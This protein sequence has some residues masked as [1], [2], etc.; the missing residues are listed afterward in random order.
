MASVEG[1]RNPETVSLERLE[2]SIRR[3]LQL[4]STLPVSLTEEREFSN[5]NYIFR[6]DIPGRRFYLKV[7][8]ERPRNFPVSVPRERVFSE[9]EG[10]RCFHRLAQG[11]I[12]IPEVLFVDDEE[13]ALA[14]SDVGAGRQ[15]LFSVLGEQFELLAE[16]AESLGRA[17]GAIHKGTRDIGS[18]RPLLEEH[19]IRKIIFDG[20][21][22]P[23]AQ[24]VFPELWT[25]LSAEMQAHRE[26]L[27]HGD[28]WSKNL[29]VKHD[30]PIA[31]VDF[32]GVSY[33]DPAF[34]L[35]TLAAVAILPAVERPAIFPEAFSF[36]QRLLHAWASACGSPEWAAAVQPRIFRAVATFI[37]ARGFGPFAHPM[38]DN[39][40]GRIYSLAR[41]LAIDPPSNLDEFEIRLRQFLGSQAQKDKSRGGFADAQL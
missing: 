2:K 22:G 41:S 30:A 4:A 21:L 37:A 25:E 6:V 35:A 3:N 14:M 33:G 23:G 31:V 26:C 8:P 15:V 16:Q 20:L 28:L 34:D 39:A 36:I 10:L 11:I 29:L 19:I 12:V 32:E 40:R 1:V 9:A 27:V 24:K 5:I 18:I 13:M 7:I 38:S 17:L